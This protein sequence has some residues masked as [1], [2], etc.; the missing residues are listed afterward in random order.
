[1][2][3]KGRHWKL[4]GETKNRI[5][6]ARL[7]RKKE[8]GYINSPEARENMRIAHLGKKSNFK[9]KIQSEKAKEKV[10]IANSGRKQ[11]E[12]HILK[13]VSKCSKEKHY[14][15]KGGEFS[16]RRGHEWKLIRKQVLIRFEFKCANC[17]AETK[18]DVHHKTPYRKVQEH[19]IENL[20][21]LCKSC[22]IKEEHLIRAEE[23]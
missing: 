1:M 3:I 7:K 23:K 21:P 9:G 16:R 2:G 5:S 10:S 12:E 17:G 22:H 8:L 11:T 6:E 19:K 13:R 4:T 15:W 18:L 14:N 20:I